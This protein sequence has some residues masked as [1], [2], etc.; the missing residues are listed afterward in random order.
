M[1]WSEWLARL[2][3]VNGSAGRTAGAADY[4]D[5]LPLCRGWS[6]GIR[7]RAIAIRWR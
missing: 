1:G 5:L 6:R 2:F 7:Y 3:P 4:S